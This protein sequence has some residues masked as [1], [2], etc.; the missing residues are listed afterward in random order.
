MDLRFG[1]QLRGGSR[2]AW[3]TVKAEQLQGP[4]TCGEVSR[5]ELVGQDCSI[6]IVQGSVPK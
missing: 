2:C 6:S 5:V 4:V 3:L 1:L